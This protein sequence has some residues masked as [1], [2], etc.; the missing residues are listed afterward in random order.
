M[1]RGDENKAKFGGTGSKVFLEKATA[2]AV[3]ISYLAFF[4]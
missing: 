2:L 1:V 4:R 3:F